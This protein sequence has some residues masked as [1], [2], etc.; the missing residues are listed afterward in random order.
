VKSEITKALVASA[1]PCNFSS[2]AAFSHR[3]QLLYLVFFLSGVSALLFETLWFRLAGLTFGNSVWASSTVLASFMAGLALGNWLAGRL[4]P[5]SRWPARLYALLEVSIGVSG[6]ALVLLFPLLTRLFAPLFRMLQPQPVALNAVRLGL[7][8]VLMVVPA[9]AMGATLPVLVRTMSR[10]SAGFGPLLGRLYGWNTLGAVAGAV[11]GEAALVERFGLRGTGLIAALLNLAA[12]GGALYVAR[13]L[14]AAPADGSSQ[15]GRAATPGGAT[16]FLMASFLAGGIVLALEV[17]WFRFLLLFTTGTSLAFALM[18]ATVLLGIALGGLAAGWLYRLDPAAERW[19]AAVALVAGFAVA[20]C[21]SGFV[22]GGPPR[23]T[24]ASIA[25]RDVRLALRLMLPVTIL[26]GLLFILL[27]RALERRIGDATRATSRLTLANTLGA[28]LGAISGGFLLLPHL[29]MERSFFALAMAYGLV[30]L[31]AMAGG[32]ERPRQPR[33][34]LLIGVAAVVFLLPLVAFPFGLLRNYFLPAV[35]QIFTGDGSRVIAQREGLTETATYLRRDLLGAPYYYRLMTNGD[36]MSGTML[37]AQRYMRLFVHLPVA[38]VPAPKHALL[39]S[40]GVGTTAQAL[41][42]LPSLQSIDVVDISRDNVELS[43]MRDFG[44]HHPLDDPRLQVH[45]EDGRFFLL[46]TGSKFDLVTAEPPPPK[47][48][49]VVNLYSREYFGLIRDRLSEGGL[50]T[51]WLPIYQLEEKETRSLLQAF[52]ATFDDCTLWAGSGAELIMMGSR[53]PMRPVSAEDLSRQWRDSTTAGE[54]ARIGV[55]SPQML[56][57]TFIADAAWLEQYIGA[58]PPLTDDFPLRL[59]YRP[60]ETIA[61]GLYPLLDTHAAQRRFAVSAWARIIWPD[62][63]RVGT[64]QS[65]LYEAALSR[66]FM[67]PGPM[68]AAA[69]NALRTSPYRVLPLLLLNTDVRQQELAAAA[70]S[71]GSKDARVSWVLGIGAM[72]Q[73]DYAGAAAMLRAAEQHA[74]PSPNLTADRKLAEELAAQGSAGTRP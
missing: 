53:G 44:G 56:G 71:R 60:V 74:K 16:A 63:L 43:R 33:E 50:A 15:E 11:V 40:Y 45:I 21:Y 18:L 54:L 70:R 59:S 65:F 8:F 68:R 61:P 10:D 39:I 73:R 38:F 41:T 25:V 58:T 64:L 13:E 36:S 26:S 23:F 32:L 30:A 2:G 4:A 67:R 24:V 48:A 12:A 55:E 47:L 72:S 29:G 31:L 1:S 57:A 28:M 34:R 37:P 3:V 46:T 19:T 51:Y 9:T 66:F 52:C 22:P 49:G 6:L 5:K 14:A 27:G 7:A 62:S 69:A 20:I 35:T 42:E 17:V